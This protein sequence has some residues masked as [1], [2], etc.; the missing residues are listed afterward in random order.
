MRKFKFPNALVIIVSF[1]FLSGLLTY[2]IPKGRYERTLNPATQ[3]EVV[4][5]GSYT[6][7]EAPPLPVFRI[8][9]SVPRGIIAGA[10]VV[11]L[12]FLVGGFF[13]V[14]DKTGAFREGIGWLASKVKGR[15]EF[16]L[17]VVGFAFALGG[18]LE[19]LQEE[20]IPMIPILL[21]LTRRLGYNAWV[22]LC[23]SYGAAVIGSTFSPVN[24]FGAVIA[25]KVAEMPFL[26]GSAFTLG[27]CIMAFALWM[28]M[29][30]RYARK[31]RVEKETDANEL[32]L[33]IP[34]RH[35]I[36]LIL[37]VAS[38]VLLISGML[39]LHWGFNEISAEFFVACLVV[40]LAGKLGVNGTFEAYAEGFKEM[41]FAAMIVGLA[42]SISLVLKEGLIQDTIIYGLFTPLQYL[43]PALSA[44]GM[45]VSQAILHITVPSNSG[46]AVLTIPILAPLSDLIGISRDVCVLAFQYG[47]ILMDMVIPTNGA[48]MAV[49]ALAGISY[50]EWIRFVAKRILVIFIFG[51]IAILVAVAAGL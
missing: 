22:M 46:Q 6:P 36:I 9:M 1:I 48:L 23:I 17:V 42:H 31:N 51:M 3:R 10:E 34:I 33:A 44:V 16:A 29:V 39:F 20:I 40:G 26:S 4:V 12:I 30:I 49:I 15:E 25:H 19:N 28:T 32:T 50:D 43:P 8:F 11:V 47:A 14:V 45:M 7:V 18:A 21:V 41:A 5:P 13:F 27:A 35:L 2:I 24:P 38:F 37:V